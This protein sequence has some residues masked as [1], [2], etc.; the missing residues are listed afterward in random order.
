M[1]RAKQ[2]SDDGED[3]REP[4]YDQ[5]SEMLRAAC[6]RFDQASQFRRLSARI[7]AERQWARAGER[8][9]SVRR[10]RTYWFMGAGFATGAAATLAIVAAVSP[11]LHGVDA[12]LAP[13]SGERAEDAGRVRLLVAFRPGTTLEAASD[14]LGSIGGR[15]AGGPDALGLW[16]VTVPADAAARARLERSPIVE[17]VGEAR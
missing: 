6:P 15:L 14:L 16:P 13:L 7:N 9:R 11:L 17:S 1:D 4:W 2:S 3:R 10:P 12:P 8:G 5:A